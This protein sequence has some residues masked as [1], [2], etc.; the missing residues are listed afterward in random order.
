MKKNIVV[1][2]LVLAGWASVFG[3]PPVREGYR[4]PSVEEYE[5]IVD[6]VMEGEL[7]AL[8]EYVTNRNIDLDYSTSGIHLIEIASEMGNEKIVSFL[9]KNEV[10][11]RLPQSLKKAIQNEHIDTALQLIDYDFEPTPEYLKVIIRSRPR[12]EFPKNPIF[13]NAMIRKTDADAVWEIT[14]IANLRA[15]KLKAIHVAAL[16]NNGEALQNFLDMGGNPNQPVESK[17]H[18]IKYQ[19]HLIHLA[20]LGAEGDNTEA[21]DVLLR[22]PKTDI[23]VTAPVYSDSR[24]SGSRT[25]TAL[26]LATQYGKIRSIRR[27]MEYGA[28][29]KGALVAAI[30]SRRMDT[31]LELLKHGAIKDEADQ[32]EAHKKALTRKQYDMAS[33]LNPVRLRLIHPSKNIG[34]GVEANPYVWGNVSYRLY[35]SGDLNAWEFVKEYPT[36]KGKRA[37][38][39]Y[40]DA[41]AENKGIS[42]FRLKAVLKE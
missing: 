39:Q 14:H 13:L 17:V 23:N 2:A 32:Q 9:I 6:A 15:T 16:G 12:M 35:R 29:P 42:F 38:I 19:F 1:L 25:G 26:K 20:I 11:N 7:D 33:L 18:F 37:I 31:L 28:D 24:G 21:L 22:H 30:D 8:I 3:E 36:K 40:I 10:Q 41:N 4:K 34:R 5:N 27:L